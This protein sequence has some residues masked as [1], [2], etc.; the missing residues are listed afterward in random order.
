MN[1][2]ITFPYND[3]FITIC[4]KLDALD[5]MRKHTEILDWFEA[6]L[7]NGEDYQFSDPSKHA[8]NIVGEY[9]WFKREEDLVA[10]RLACGI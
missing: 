7:V 10:F 4:R 8:G 3:A 5:I 2:S 1:K 9:I 6:H